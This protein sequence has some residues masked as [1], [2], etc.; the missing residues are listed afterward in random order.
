MNE[1]CDWELGIVWLSEKF[2]ALGIVE[3]NVPVGPLMC[4]G[5]AVGS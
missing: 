5:K 1:D 2:I 3:D 4:K